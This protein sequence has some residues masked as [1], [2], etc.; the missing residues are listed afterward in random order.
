MP[1]AF[2]SALSPGPIL[3]PALILSVTGNVPSLRWA[4]VASTP[5]SSVTLMRRALT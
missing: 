2:R 1:L 3:A 5:A 4:T